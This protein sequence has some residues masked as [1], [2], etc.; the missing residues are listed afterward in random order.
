MTRARIATIATIA[1]VLIG[2]ALYAYFYSGLALLRAERY[3][4]FEL[5][6]EC[7]NELQRYLVF[8]R[9]SPPAHLLY[10]EASLKDQMMSSDDAMTSAL[11]HLARIPDSSELLLAERQASSMART[12]EA[13]IAFVQFLRPALAESKFRRAIELDSENFDAWY[14]LWKLLDQTARS[15]QAETAFWHAYRL[16]EKHDKTNP[17]G[18]R[19][20]R[21]FLLRDWY[22]SQF[23]PT[24]ANTNMDRVMGL[25]EMD[26]SADNRTELLRYESFIES[27]P[28]SPIGYVGQA[29]VYYRALDIDRAIKTLEDGAE[30]MEG[31]ES[32]PSYLATMIELLSVR[33]RLPEAKELFKNWP[34]SDHES[35]EYWSTRAIV[36]HEADSNYG[37]AVEAYEQALKIWPGPADWNFR[38][39]MS[40][41]LAILGEVERA[42][43]ERTRVKELESLFTDKMYRKQRAALDTLTDMK[44]LQEIADF[45]RSI[46]RSKEAE[47]WDEVIVGLRKQQQSA[48][49][50]NQGAA[51][52]KS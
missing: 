6:T 5:W 21:V 51:E 38:N 3:A 1:I 32:D 33:G 34:D 14:G 15:N 37:A 13:Q 7:R 39:K 17:L 46:D 24:T 31:E 11:G 30:T 29:R 18:E 25:L 22:M 12:K 45:Y 8:H 44:G 49:A 23:F 35:F 41:C 20:D 52:T 36:L 16:V 10:A 2:G 40:N 28:E 4:N 50:T 47:C 27:E 48:R 26:R 42:A 43:K 9:D 19:Y